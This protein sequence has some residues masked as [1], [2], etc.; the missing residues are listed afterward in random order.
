MSARRPDGG[1][2]KLPDERGDRRV[3]RHLRVLL[4]LLPAHARRTIAEP[5]E[6]TVADALAA[7]RARGRWALAWTHG[8]ETAALVRL[9]VREHREDARSGA[10]REEWSFMLTQDIRHAL[11]GLR[12][13]PGTTTVSVLTLA[14]GIG[15]VTAI[16]SVIDGVLLRNLSYAEPGRVIYVGERMSDGSYA[17]VSYENF[18]DWR[19]AGVFE[20][21]GATIGNSVNVTG[22]G[23]PERIRGEFVTAG[24]FDVIGVQ[25]AVGRA[26]APGEDEPGGERTAVLSWGWWQARFGA[27]PSTI[28]RTVMLNNLPH[29]IVGV[30]PAGFRSPWDVPDAWISLHSIPRDF[31][32]ENRNFQA[33]LARLGPDQTLE[34]ALA[35][36]ESVHE[37]LVER[38]PEANGGTSVW[39]F[40]LSSFLAD[41]NRD[42]LLGLGAAVGLLLLIACANVAN[43]Q[44]ARTAARRRELAVRTA[45]GGGR[46]R[47]ARLLVVENAL[48]FLIGGVAGLG[49][50]WLGVRGLL[51]LQP[52]YTSFYDVR[53]STSTAVVGLAAAAAA[54]LLFGLAPALEAFRAEPA[55]TLREG[56]RGGGSGRGTRRFRAALVVGQLALSTSLL[57]GAGLLARTMSA[58]M[59]VDPGFDRESLLTLE[60]RL[61]E[62]RYEGDGER[63]VFYDRLHEELQALPGVE[64]V[65]FASD[66]PFSGNSASMRLLP[67]G[68]SVE[69]TNAPVVRANTVSPD[70]RETMGIPLLAGRDLAETDGPGASFA[71][72]VS[73]SA[74][75]RLFGGTAGAVGTR[76]YASPDRSVTGE[77]VG[78]VGDVQASLVDPPLAHVYV[79]YRQS[80]TLFMSVAVRTSG[81]PMALAPAVRDAVWSVDPDQPVWEVMPITE[82]MAGSAS[83][84][85]FNAVLVL[86]FACTAVLLASLGL[87]GVMAYTVRLRER[88]LGVR[89]ALGASPSSVM[90]MVVGRGMLLV[91]AGLAAGLV[92]AWWLASLLESLLFGVSASDP[93]TFLAALGTLA[94]VGALSTWLPARRALG[95]DPTETLHEA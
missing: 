32:R 94:L 91:A 43:L 29:T 60:F 59:G 62:N 17:S 64:A 15:A 16:A 6:A 7:A 38:Y 80:P 25:P 28:G 47:L 27:D 95:L 11:R 40:P 12:R 61:P 1:G 52:A 39:A 22:E 37:G 67:E 8:R 18:L 42:F 34:A 76:L 88:E 30:M 49:V 90:R 75:E 13:S 63:L 78:V 54:G 41:R 50:A 82:R 85:R 74:A 46:R 31:G 14:L 20:A 23:Q 81:D 93:A 48:L 33:A 2:A 26:I 53:L 92:I 86:V 36:L 79:S 35:S 45:L 9:V 84:T 87:Y 44:L 71:V 58:L 83:R 21:L 77:V 66:L 57:I 24:Y 3:P 10:P 73:R 4:R 51:A 70:Y 72:L 5:L 89:L 69:W 65:G 19:D 55:A 68:S 56:D